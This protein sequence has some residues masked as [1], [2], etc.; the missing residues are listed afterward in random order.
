MTKKTSWYYSEHLE[1][2]VNFEHIKRIYPDEN[3][4]DEGNKVYLICAVDNEK[5]F[6]IEK[7]Y[8]IEEHFENWNRIKNIVEN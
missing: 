5:L 7:T 4:D 8:E 2:F 1:S 3:L 6:F